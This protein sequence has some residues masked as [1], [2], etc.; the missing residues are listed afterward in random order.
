MSEEK[1]DGRSKEARE[2]KSQ[3]LSGIEAP[4]A[5][6][7]RQRNPDRKPFGSMVQKLAFPP[8][9]GYHRHWFNEEPGRIAQALENGYLHVK[10]NAS[11]KPVTRVV[12]KAGQQAFLMEIP[13]EW[14]DKDMADQQQAVN[15]KE[16]TIRRGQVD[17]SDP[18]DRDGRFT[19]TAQ[20]R[21]IDIRSTTA[22]R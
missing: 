5:L 16:D 4:D 15:D 9:A 10:D 19:N 7:G 11:Q 12:N 3:G 22:R 20:G 14:F 6:E 13:Q 1:I 18:R 21:R 17:A 8:R 2:M